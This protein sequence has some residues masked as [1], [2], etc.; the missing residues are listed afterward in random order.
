M[1]IVDEKNYKYFQYFKELDLPVY[2]RVDLGEFNAALPPFLV[3]QKFEEL[4][5]QEVK[6]LDAKFDGNDK[7]R[8]LTFQV[9]T[10][11]VAKQIHM[12]R[13]TDKYG[14]ESIIPKTGYKVYRYASA[15]MM[16]YSS[17]SKEW[18]LG[19]FPEFGSENEDF[20]S[21]SIL[22]R[23]LS[24]ALSSQGII[25]FWGVPVDEGIV[26]LNQKQSNG[27]AIYVDVLNKRV[28][29][30]DGARDLKGSFCVLR[31]DPNLRNK[32]IDMKS[33]QLLSFLT[34]NVVY[35][36]DRGLPMVQ[37]QMIQAITKMAIGMVHPMESFKP[38]TDLSL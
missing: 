21:K 6:E 33:E 26:V 14:S 8:L 7:A 20:S 12:M 4:S 28:I 19:C 16:V 22:N 29:S 11:I 13:P 9:A 34:T 15:G 23:Y 2:L 25:A 32:N 27:E 30:L 35:F 5:S 24:W 37:R 10:P 38:R 17:A 18:T 36:D 31:L 1:S 3:E